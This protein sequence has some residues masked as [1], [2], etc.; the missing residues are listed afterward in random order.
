MERCA[1]CGMLLGE[2]RRWGHDPDNPCCS[3]ECA[4]MWRLVEVMNRLVEFMAADMALAANLE[5]KLRGV[6]KP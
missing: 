1:V 2:A 5:Y 3:Q 4:R 6:I